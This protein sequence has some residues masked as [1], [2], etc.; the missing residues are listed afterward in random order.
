MNDLRKLREE[1]LMEQTIITESEPRDADHPVLGPSACFR[2]LVLALPHGLLTAS[3]IMRFARNDKCDFFGMFVILLLL[4][5]CVNTNVDAMLKKRFGYSDVADAVFAWCVLAGLIFLR[6]HCDL[7]FGPRAR[8]LTLY[9]TKHGFFTAWMSGSLRKFVIIWFTWILSI[10][11]H[12]VPLLLTSDTRHSQTLNALTFSVVS[13]FF[14]MQMYFILHISCCLEL[15]I[16]AFC[17]RFFFEGNYSQGISEWNA[18]Q[19]ILRRTAC[20]I[21]VCFIFL[22]AS[23]VMALALTSTEMARAHWIGD[24]GLSRIAL[25]RFLGW[26]PFA[27]L[28][29]Y[30]L[31]K[32]AGVTEKCRRAP[33]LVNSLIITPE[34]TINFERQ[35]M[36]DFMMQTEA[37][38]YVLGIR[39][40]VFMVFKCS[41]VLLL[42]SLTMVTQLRVQD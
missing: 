38:F 13:A 35:Y 21:E 14:S 5:L 2:R 20:V 22:Q 27:F 25:L 9:A 24:E 34:E 33:S 7:S 23:V 40:T 36:V 42:A 28:M 37:G 10:I 8:S 16:D 26:L 11:F 12:S 6:K 31:F 30:C 41:Y 19:A 32:A 17:V 39:L 3:G 15:M 4:L 18:V 1:S 29:L